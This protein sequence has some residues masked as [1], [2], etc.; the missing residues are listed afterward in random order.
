MTGSPK[1]CQART[2]CAQGR[3]WSVDDRPR[4]RYRTNSLAPG[5]RVRAGVFVH[6]NQRT[7][8]DI[9]LAIKDIPTSRMEFR[10][11]L[12]LPD[13]ILRRMI[14]TMILAL[15]LMQINA[16]TAFSL[17]CAELIMFLTRSRE[18]TVMVKTDQQRTL[19]EKEEVSQGLCRSV[20]LEC[21]LFVPASVLLVLF[22]LRPF[23]L[24]MPFVAALNKNETVFALYGVFGVLSYQFPF[25]LIRR[26]VTRMALDTLRSFANIVLKQDPSPLEPEM[27]VGPKAISE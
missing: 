16:G 12:L 20:W 2:L 17:G 26:I 18:I 4:W 24:L 23:I 27:S 1:E 5:G 6:V 14:L 15:P 7:I 25:G 8:G 10:I 11:W 3:K 22:V 9:T 19:F 21:L 13:L